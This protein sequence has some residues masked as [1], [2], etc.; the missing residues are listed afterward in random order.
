ME[1][2]SDV[3][4]QRRRICCTVLWIG[5]AQSTYLLNLFI[6]VNGD[7]LSQVPACRFSTFFKPNHCTVF[8]I[9]LSCIRTKKKKSFEQGRWK[10]S[11]A[12]FLTSNHPTIPVRFNWS[13]FCT[14]DAFHINNSINYFWAS[15]CKVFLFLIYFLLSFFQSFLFL[16]FFLLPSFLPS[17]PFPSLPFPV[18]SCPFLSFP[19]LPF[20]SFSFPFLPFLSFSFPFLCFP[21][22]SFP[23]L[24]F[25]PSF[26][27]FSFCRSFF[28][29]CL[30]TFFLFLFSPFCLYVCLFFLCKG[31]CVIPGRAFE[32]N[33]LR[34]SEA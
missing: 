15:V 13:V 33:T 3:S 4:I 20:L 7:R 12:Q 11:F 17:L 32:G 10:F 5:D 1:C 9:W 22:L 24:P 28:L 2:V 14:C 8:A 31:S 6:F 16:C 26:L 18:L 25:L 19:S 21:C 30:L 34:P 29:S 27:P 23:F